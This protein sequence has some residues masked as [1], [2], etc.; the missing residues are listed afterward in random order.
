MISVLVEQRLKREIPEMTDVT[1]HIDPE[2]DEAKPSCSPLHAEALAR[3]AS[4]WPSIPAANERQRI[5]FHYLG[6]RIDVEVCF[7]M[8]ACLRDG[9]DPEALRDELAAAMR[10]DSVFRELRVYFG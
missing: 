4:L 1:V 10:E 2:N 7:P 3:P 9:S 6:C 5:L 8:T